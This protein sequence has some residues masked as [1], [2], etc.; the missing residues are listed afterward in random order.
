[1]L[2]L[3]LRAGGPSGSVDCVG[4][5]AWLNA[6]PDATLE[7]S[8]AGSVCWRLLL[9]DLALGWQ[10]LFNLSHLSHFVAPSGVMHRALDIEQLAHARCPPG[11]TNLTL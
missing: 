9:C 8:W 3:N 2:E 5:A 10:A 1:M 4:V 11:G 6:G 7:A